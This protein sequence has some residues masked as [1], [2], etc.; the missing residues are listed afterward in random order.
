MQATPNLAPLI[1][2]FK[3]VGDTAVSL[4]P[5]QY[6]GAIWVVPLWSERGLIGLLLLGSKRDDGL[7]TQEEINIARVSGERLID[8]QASAEMSRRL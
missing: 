1:E 7:Y 4:S 8:T 3:A 2:Q 6:N 5:S